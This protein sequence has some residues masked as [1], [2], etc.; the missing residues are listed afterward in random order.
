MV[1]SEIKNRRNINTSIMSDSEI[2]TIAIVG[3]LMTIDSEKSWLGFCRKNLKELFPK[4]CNRT[5][6]NR[7]RRFL[8]RVIELIR[9]KLTEILG[10][11]S[12]PHRIVDSM[13]IYACKFGRA[14]FHKA[15]KGLASY[16]RCASKKET[17]FG[18]KFH[19][20][21]AI[22]GY[23]TDISITSANKDDRDALW[24]LTN[25]KQ[26]LTIISDKGYIGADFA[27]ELFKERNATIISGKRNNSKTQLPKE[28]RQL[29]FKKRRLIETVYSQLAGQLNIS[30]VLAKSHLG[31]LTRI[32]TKVLAHNLCH[33]I[34]KTINKTVNVRNIKELLFG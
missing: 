24:D 32:E 12:D 30:R 28:L 19:S 8:F 7:T 17:Y 14:K 9:K 29:I 22:D 18:F 15:F 26:S 3:E 13:P 20:L 2:I 6:F 11:Y 10:Y 16:G 5:R 31:L 33:F 27:E 23:I 21:I 25:K 34:N 1:P 4:F